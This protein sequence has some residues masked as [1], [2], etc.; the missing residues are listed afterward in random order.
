MSNADNRGQYDW[1]VEIAGAAA[2]A[3]AAAFAAAKLAPIT[4][5]S[6]SM[7]V[8]VGGGGVFAAAW[9]AMRI[10]PAEAR[11]LALPDFEKTAVGVE[12]L[13]LEYRYEALDEL[14]LDQP[15]VEA[16]CEA[17]AELLLDDPLAAPMPDPRVVHLFAEGRM[18]S[19]GQL[20]CRIDAHLAD[21]ARAA[22]GVAIDAADALSEALAELRRSLRQA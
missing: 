12:M 16:E 9:T 21:G 8:L 11:R 20:K 17:V 22:P 19:A 2:P 10:I 4:G 15:L 6:L 18:P 5:W 3:A 1:L 13:L 14:L 7:A